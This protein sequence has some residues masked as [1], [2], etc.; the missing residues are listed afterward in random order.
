MGSGIS[1]PALASFSIIANKE[2]WLNTSERVACLWG[3]YFC[4][5][6]KTN[7]QRVPRPV[8]YAP[9]LDYQTSFQFGIISILIKSTIVLASAAHLLKATIIMLRG[10]VSRLSHISWLWTAFPHQ[11]SFQTF[12]WWSFFHIQT[13]SLIHFQL[14]EIDIL[15]SGKLYSKTE[16]SRA[17]AKDEKSCKIW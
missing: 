3:L 10:S 5:L 14:G 2:F 1:F 9:P 15:F 12:E 11:P 16:F 8:Q 13:Q 4:A 17:E 6:F 7:H